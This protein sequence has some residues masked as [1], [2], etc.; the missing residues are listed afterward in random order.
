MKVTESNQ[1]S[2]LLRDIINYEHKSF[3]VLAM[4]YLLKNVNGTVRK[5]VY[6]IIY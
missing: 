3:K 5:I 2:S 1:H 6:K 4:V